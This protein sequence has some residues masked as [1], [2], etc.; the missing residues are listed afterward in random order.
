MSTLSASRIDV[1]DVRSKIN[2]PE[3]ILQTVSQGPIDSILTHAYVNP[4]SASMTTTLLDKSLPIEG[5]LNINNILDY[6][7]EKGLT[8]EAL[9]D[10]NIFLEIL[11]NDP[12]KYWNLKKTILNL[13]NPVNK[14]MSNLCTHT[15]LHPLV[16]TEIADAKTSDITKKR[17]GDDIPTR[18]FIEDDQCVKIYGSIVADALRGQHYS[19]QE[20]C[21]Q[22]DRIHPFLD[23]DSSTDLIL[24][25]HVNQIIGACTR[26]IREWCEDAPRVITPLILRNKG[27]P[28]RK[29]HV[30]FP[31]IVLIKQYWKRISEEVKRELPMLSHIIDTNYSGLRL[32][33]C[34]KKD[35]VFSMYY[36]PPYDILDSQYVMN[37]LMLLIQTRIRAWPGE[38]PLK[39]TPRHAHQFEASDP[40]HRQSEEPTTEMQ[41]AMLKHVD[42][43][44]FEARWADDGYRLKRTQPGQCLVCHREHQS[45]NAMIILQR[46]WIVYK[47]RRDMKK[48]HQLEQFRE[49]SPEEIKQHRRFVRNRLR[50]EI[51]YQPPSFVHYTD[52]DSYRNEPL[53]VPVAPTPEMEADLNR[54]YYKVVLPAIDPS[55][56]IQVIW[57]PMDTGKTYQLIIYLRTMFQSGCIKSFAFLSTRIKFARSLHTKLHKHLADLCTVGCYL[58]KSKSY[59]NDPCLVISTESLAKSVKHMD[60][61]I[62]DEVT[63]CLV[64]M[65]SGLHDRNLIDNQARLV[66]MIRRAK[67]IVAMDADI[68]DRAI[69]FIHEVRPNDRIHLSHN[70]VK[71]RTGWRFHLRM[72]KLDW[73]MK[74]SESL[75]KGQ[76][77]VCPVA[78]SEEGDLIYRWVTERC[79]IPDEYVRFYRQ[80]G[81]DYAEELHDVETHW[82]NFRVLIYTS[83][84]NVGIDFSEVEHPIKHYDVMFVYTS[85]KSNTVREIKQMMGR[86]RNIKEQ[87]VYHCQSDSR[88]RGWVPTTTDDIYRDIEQRLNYQNQELNREIP[89]LNPILL[90]HKK[91]QQM[92]RDFHGE[93]ELHND[94]R[95]DVIFGIKN[96]PFSRLRMAN[97]LEINL[98]TVYH[99]IMLELKMEDQGFECVSPPEKPRHLHL[100]K[101]FTEWCQA[102]REE[103][104]SQILYRMDRIL[105]EQSQMTANQ[106]LSID[107]RIQNGQ[108]TEADKL[109]ART[110]KYLGQ[111]RPECRSAVTAEQIDITEHHV[112]SLRVQTQY[113]VEDALLNDL[114]NLEGGAIDPIDLA[115]RAAIHEVSHLLGVRNVMTDRT[116]AIRCLDIRN[117]LQDW[118]ALCPKLMNVFKLRRKKPP[119]DY[120]GVREI[121]NAI[122]KDIGLLELQEVGRSDVI[123]N[124]K[125]ER[126][127]TYKLFAPPEIDR[128]IEQL[129][130]RPPINKYKNWRDTHGTID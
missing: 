123:V 44:Q 93:R 96:S 43:T 116:S 26:I 19:L 34:K 115:K 77:I 15:N 2:L 113:R 6:L 86:V 63:S 24:D 29:V 121:L 102:T 58:D 110:H 107:H 111:V 18:L 124:G 3:V 45:D 17:S 42:Q 89:R 16:C 9:D 67:Y 101:E 20:V 91:Y 25:D 69:N 95:G 23:L 38:T 5:A 7:S 87:V 99:D 125:K 104:K 130:P 127:Y 84:I 22:D 31:N 109:S 119:E 4:T 97:M 105:H 65:D 61:V 30:H 1:S 21:R 70:K 94:P 41:E 57:S 10:M 126:R 117:R 98:S 48:S 78:S 114:N 81:D 79:G 36:D 54:R 88:N 108:A 73:Y 8:D 53:T 103:E 28:Q 76:N 60:L 122:L 80:S 40:E 129:E 85:I 27:N 82:R 90:D 32:P 66:N 120:R 46:G 14:D 128:T 35:D 72:S 83:T 62:M 106:L 33:L 50:N 12:D 71:K 13:S 64:Q 59:A 100:I 92:L 49:L 37:Q 56:K 47:C 11:A 118:I 74:I 52:Y 39:V 112:H 75:S 68:D 51:T 55:V